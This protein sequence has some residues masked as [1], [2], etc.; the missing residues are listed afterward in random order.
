MFYENFNLKVRKVMKKD[1]K[2]E[3][4]EVVASIVHT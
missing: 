1:V 4:V 3:P 2:T